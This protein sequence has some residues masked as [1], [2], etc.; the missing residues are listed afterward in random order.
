MIE[1]KNYQRTAVNK[2]K[3]ILVELLG[4]P[5]QRQRVVL[6]APTGSGKTVMTSAAMDELTRELQT[7][8]VECNYSAVAWVWLAPNKLHEQS[9]RSMRNFFSETRS[10]RPMWFD[11]CEIG[12]GI[13]PGEVLFLNWE[14]VNKDNNLLIRDNEQNRTLQVLLERTRERMPVVAIIDEAHMFTGRNA[15]KSERLLREI[16]KPKIELCVTA[17]PEKIR[18]DYTVPV[19]REDVIEEE[20][21][22]RGVNLNPGVK[23]DNEQHALSVN[24]RLLVRALKKRDELAEAYRVAGIGINPLLLVQLPNDTKESL[25]DEERKIADEVK[26]YLADPAVDITEENGRLAVWLS[27]EKSPNLADIVRKDNMT[28]VLLFKQAIALG[29]DCPRAAVLLIFRDIKSVVFTTQT[30]GRILRMPEQ[31]FYIDE[32]LNFGYVYTN[33]SAEIVQ[34]SQDD[35]GYLS[36]VYASRR[37][38]L[39]NI[40]LRSVYMD[41]HLNRNRLGPGFRRVL[42]EVVET[43]LQS[44]QGE[45]GIDLTTGVSDGQPVQASLFSAEQTRFRTLAHRK[46]LNLDVKYLSVEL[47]KDMHLTGINGEVEVVQKARVA[48]NGNEV[49]QVFRKYCGEHLGGFA[50]FDSTPVLMN[51]LL[52]VME[53]LFGITEMEAPKVILN[54]DNTYAN[55][56]FFED[57]IASALRRFE[58]ELQMKNKQLNPLRDYSVQQFEIPDIRLYNSDVVHPCDEIFNHALRPYFEQNNASKP[59]RDFARWIDRQTEWVDWWYKNG[60]DGKQHFAIPYTDSGGRKRCFYVDFIVLLKN[61]TICLFDTKTSGSDEDSPEKNNALWEYIE[62]H[63]AKG[64]R[65]TGGILVKKGENWYYPGGIIETDDNTNGWSLLEIDRL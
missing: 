14:S 11:E 26:S 46:R 41:H 37:E 13:R 63:N 18:S 6:K 42:R 22:K 2:L 60:D 7:G 32:R 4:Y 21:I 24:Q 39:E 17:T 50:K 3:A 55:R 9:Y 45:L 8:S 65:M 20:M 31:H 38:R 43:K 30:V 29:W 62:E 10:L 19:R 16:I 1:L 44:T 49:E 23:S 40:Q 47:P 5:E 15:E 57:A 58:K 12:E 33:L 25:G 36:T 61:G 59:E 54:R 64:K 56:T 34:V 52:D 48:I 28:Q 51:A 35:M 53:A 27:K